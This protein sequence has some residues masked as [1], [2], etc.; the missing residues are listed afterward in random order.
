M[1][2]YL[3]LSCRRAV[4]TGGAGHLG[5]VTAELFLEQGSS[6]VLTDIVPNV[7]SKELFR[8]FTPYAGR[9]S[10]IQA[11]VSD[12]EQ[13]K[14]MLKQAAEVLGGIDI[15]VNCAVKSKIVLVENMATY[16][17]WDET[18]NVALSGTFY[19]CRE[20]FPYMKPTGGSIVNISSIA[21]L[22]ALPRGTTHYSAAKSGV[23]GL[24]RSLALEWAKY[25]IRVNSVAPGQ[26]DTLPLRKLM[27]NKSFA[28]DILN[29]IPMGRVGNSKEIALAVL[30][31]ASSASSFITGQTIVA[32]GGATTSM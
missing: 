21:G 32:D 8:P 20:V 2:N 10:Y 18:I 11:S 26:F 15:L 24:T 13:V 16:E 5:R 3:D 23:L 7:A 9:W 14:L 19:C 1:N 17:E 30:Y 25:S 27:E 22:V 12:R 31:L 28:N 6:V 29:S 4:I